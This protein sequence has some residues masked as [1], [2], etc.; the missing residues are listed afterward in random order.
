MNYQVTK[1]YRHF[2]VDGEQLSHECLPQSA[3]APGSSGLV[4]KEP[5]RA[6][7]ADSTVPPG[8]SFLW[9]KTGVLLTVLGTSG[10]WCAQRVIDVP[11]LKDRD[12]NWLEGSGWRSTSLIPTEQW[13][14]QGWT[15]ASPVPRLLSGSTGT[16]GRDRHRERGEQRQGWEAPRHSVSYNFGMDFTS[17]D[18]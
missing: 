2:T 12:F 14:C 1:F 4:R 3:Q 18:K 6:D 7:T 16:K 10:W 9:A 13:R 15:A 11:L 8:S 5:W 17:L